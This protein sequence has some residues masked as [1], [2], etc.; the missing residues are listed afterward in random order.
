MTREELL[1]LLEEN[2]KEYR[3]TAFSSVKRNKHMNEL[4]ET[5][6]VQLREN[7]Q[8]A[9]KTIDALLVDF[10]NFVGAGQGLDWGLHTKQFNEGEQEANRPTK[11]LLKLLSDG[12]WHVFDQLPKKLTVQLCIEQGFVAT[13]KVDRE[14]V[15]GVETYRIAL[16][17]TRLGKNALQKYDGKIIYER[18]A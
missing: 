5:D 8:L 18:N 3:K 12:Q 14:C 1:H 15:D 6:F 7:R 2:A 11:K 4:S 10:I 13:K 17:I 9:Q 16:R